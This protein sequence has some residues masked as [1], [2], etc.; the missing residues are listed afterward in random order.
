[1]NTSLSEV[2]VGCA[3]CHHLRTTAMAEGGV[4][5][6]QVCPFLDWLVFIGVWDSECGG[7]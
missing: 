3:G 1:M 6:K 7:R 2:H 4:A 5:D